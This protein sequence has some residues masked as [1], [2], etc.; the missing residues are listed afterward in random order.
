MKENRIMKP[1]TRLSRGDGVNCWRLVVKLVVVG[2]GFGNFMEA[3]G[4]R[5][6][7]RSELRCQMT[8][9]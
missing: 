8:S 5:T 4:C 3:S 1:R 2:G 6:A 9:F 7:Y